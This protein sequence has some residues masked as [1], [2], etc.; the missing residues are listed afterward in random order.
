MFAVS[1]WLSIACFSISFS[2][3]CN[4]GTKEKKRKPSSKYKFI[5]Y[6]VSLRKLNKWRRPL[7]Q[8]SSDSTP[9]STIVPRTYS[10]PVR[11]ALVRRTT[12]VSL[13]SLPPPTPTP[14]ISSMSMTRWRERRNA[15]SNRQLSW[16]WWLQCWVVWCFLG[17]VV[18]CLFLIAVI[19][20]CKGGR[21]KS[22]EFVG[23]ADSKFLSK[24]FPNL[25]VTINWRRFFI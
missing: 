8:R 15:W 17:G 22:K 16:S 5:S 10:S 19:M 2:C 12:S 7:S 14:W 21:S 11:T 24:F 6:F 9:A 18:L 25:Y 4:N 3:E 23:E 13:A 20:M 1:L